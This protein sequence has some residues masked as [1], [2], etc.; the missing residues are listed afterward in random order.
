ML[1]RQI[2]ILCNLVTSLFSDKEEN[3]NF[4]LFLILVECHQVL[5]SYF[6]LVDYATQNSLYVQVQTRILLFLLEQKQRMKRFDC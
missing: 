5:R 1:L 3:L 6:L 2:Y 4:K